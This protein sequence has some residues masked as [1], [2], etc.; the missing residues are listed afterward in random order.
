MMVRAL[1]RRGGRRKKAGV[2]LLGQVD[3]RSQPKS[4]L[5]VIDHDKAKAVAAAVNAINHKHKRS[6]VHNGTTALS[7]EWR[8]LADR[9]SPSV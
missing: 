5:D 1:W 2:L 3:D 6:V 8:P 4:F 9:C 7:Q